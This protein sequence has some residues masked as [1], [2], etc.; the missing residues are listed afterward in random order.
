MNKLRIVAF[1][2]MLIC[3]ALQLLADGASMVVKTVDGTT[4]CFALASN[5]KVYLTDGNLNVRTSD[6]T[7]TFPLQSLASITYNQSVNVNSILQNSES[8]EVDGDLVRFPAADIQRTITIV[9][10][11]G[12]VMDSCVLAAGKS[13]ELSLSDYQPGVYI[14]TINGLSSKITIQ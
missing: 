12:I 6:G 1:Q 10:L 3:C 5:P 7:T 4:T 9:S 8:Y 13:S 14:I 11:N 2:V